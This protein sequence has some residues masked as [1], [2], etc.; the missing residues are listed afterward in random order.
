MPSKAPA[1]TPTLAVFRR[2]KQ[3]AQRSSGLQPIGFFGILR[4]IFPTATE[5]MKK[6]D[7]ST[8]T[9][10]AFYRPGIGDRALKRK[11]FIFVCGTVAGL[12]AAPGTAPAATVQ[13][14]D[15][16]A[17]I[18]SF[19]TAQVERAMG[20]PANLLRAI[21]LAETG[22]WNADKQAS[23][24]WPWTV[25][26][27]GRGRYF[28]SKKEAL[29]EV[30]MLLD[31]GIT[32]IDVGCMQINLFYHGGAF[33]GLEQALD[34][35]ANAAYAG[36]YLKNLHGAAGDW[37]VA[38]GYY[39]SATPERGTAYREK[40]LALWDRAGDEGRAVQPRSQRRTA[41]RQR[42]THV[43]AS[44]AT[45]SIDMARTAKL[46]ARLRLTRAEERRADFETMRKS[47]LAFW[48]EARASGLPTTHISKMRRARADA[49]RKK[50]LFAEESHDTRFEKR[51]KTQLQR[52]RL[53]HRRP[54]APS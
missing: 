51:R 53:S 23:F 4:W 28:D 2:F 25:M 37:T 7:R 20:I 13:P 43:I 36:Q 49:A 30:E 10:I 15:K 6:P 9:V 35:A 24:A 52:W 47:D 3:P 40:V 11:I 42:T 29:A 50:D 31:K 21:S 16:T 44:R 39:H 27:E 38:A 34:P 22:R 48:R 54:K 1:Q 5:R 18:C 32:N 19:E 41:S 14:L 8:G 45:V 26:A 46:N 12:L 17:E 33:S